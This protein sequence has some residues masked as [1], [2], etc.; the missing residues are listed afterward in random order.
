M[1]RT[2]LMFAAESNNNPEVIKLL[3]DRGADINVRD[4]EEEMV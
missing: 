2:A 3:L 4:E 1:G